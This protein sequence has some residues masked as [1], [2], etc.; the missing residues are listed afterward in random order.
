MIELFLELDLATD[1]IGWDGLVGG[2]NC[3]STVGW[4][5][6]VYVVKLVTVVLLIFYVVY[7]FEFHNKVYL[8]TIWF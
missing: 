5:N 6:D 4:E 1:L 7:F 3:S 8:E 2:V